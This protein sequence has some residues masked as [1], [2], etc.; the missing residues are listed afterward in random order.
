M[1]D[2]ASQPAQSARVHNR[3]RPSRVPGPSLAKSQGRRYHP[4]IVDDGDVSESRV[5]RDERKKRR[6]RRRSH[7]ITTRRP[8]PSMT[9][10]L[11]TIIALDV[12]Y[13]ISTRLSEQ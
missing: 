3:A 5:D 13:I 1:L 4:E 7:T 10:P 11:Q 12:N 8:E 2:A 9:G 6:L